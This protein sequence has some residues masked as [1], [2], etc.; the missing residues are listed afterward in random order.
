MI[1]NGDALQLVSAGVVLLIGLS[2]AIAWIPA[3]G[4]YPG[5]LPARAFITL[6]LFAVIWEP[7]GVG[8]LGA[9]LAGMG[10]AI[11]WAGRPD[12]E[13]PRPRR[14]GLFVAA[15]IAGL[16][17]LAMIV[18]WGPMGGIPEQARI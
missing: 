11:W 8:V 6:G 15:I 10:A 16:L 13:L 2:L 1:S 5:G 4:R 9:I 14:L 12:P 18:G 17:T 7:G 3:R